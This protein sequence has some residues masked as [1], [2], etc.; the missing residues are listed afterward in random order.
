[1]EK[2]IAGV[3]RYFMSAIDAKLKFALTLE[4]S[5]ITATN[6]RDFY[7]RFKK[8]YPAK[9]RSESGSQITA[10]KT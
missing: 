5:R 6:I 10:Q 7:F 2:I 3:K 4:Y 1:M 8:A 9:I